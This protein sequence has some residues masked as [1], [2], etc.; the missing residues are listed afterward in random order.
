MGLQTMSIRLP[1]VIAQKVIDLSKN[2]QKSLN[3][4]I[5][6]LIQIA[7]NDLNGPGHIEL[8]KQSPGSESDDSH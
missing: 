4:T 6:T 1:K 3:E 5:I 2:Y 7:L 8:T